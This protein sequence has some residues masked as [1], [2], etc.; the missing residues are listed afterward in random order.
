MDTSLV[1]RTAIITG[2]SLG[3][4]LATAQ[5]FYQAGARVALLARRREPLDEARARILELKAPDGASAPP[6]GG[7]TSTAA[8]PD[9]ARGMAKNTN[10]A[11]TVH[12]WVMRNP[13]RAGPITAPK[14]PRPMPQPM[15]VV[16]M[17]AGYS[18]AAMA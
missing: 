12:P 16:R 13:P 10:R 5:A 1:G 8:T 14:R 11:G 18:R 4:G 7:R 6:A 15:P 17:A 9:M 2:G 3:L